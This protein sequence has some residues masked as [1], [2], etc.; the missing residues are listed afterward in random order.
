M[1]AATHFGHFYDLY[2]SHFH[3]ESSANLISPL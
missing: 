2:A 1:T 3:I